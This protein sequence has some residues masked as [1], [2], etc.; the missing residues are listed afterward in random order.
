MYSRMLQ[1]HPQKEMLNI[2][3][4]ELTSIIYGGSYLP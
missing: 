4:Y 1:N 3:P 2:L